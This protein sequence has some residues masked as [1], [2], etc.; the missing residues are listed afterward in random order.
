MRVNARMSQTHLASRVVYL[1]T[2]IGCD[3]FGIQKKKTDAHKRTLTFTHT[4]IHMHTRSVAVRSDAKRNGTQ[5]NTYHLRSNYLTYAR[6]TL[7][8]CEGNIENE[9]KAQTVA[10]RTKWMKLF[11]L[12]KCQMHFRA[13]YCK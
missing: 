1:R 8:I 3:V 9:Q 6:H 4:R 12:G 5:A 11:C 10:R 2:Q 7:S 13:Y